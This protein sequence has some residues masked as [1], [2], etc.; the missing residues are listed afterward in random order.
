MTRNTTVSLQKTGRVAELILNRPEVLNAENWSMAHD[1]HGALD[2]LENAADISAVILSGAGRSF[3]SGVDLGA[4]SRGELKIDWFRSFDQAMRRIEQLDALTVAK[5]RGYAIGGG[6]QLTLACDLRVATPDARFGL[7]AVLEALIPGM[8]TYRLP[9]FI[10]LGRARRM[11]LTGEL[12]SSEEALRIG[13]VDWVVPE[14]QLTE[15]IDALI[16]RMSTGSATARGFTK[17]LITSSFE[18]DYDDAFSKYLE[19]Q[20]LSLRSDDHTRAMEEYRRRKGS[21]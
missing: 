9:R 14:E 8:G 17:K 4:L 7:P 20:E 6:L 13:L 18:S 10:G 3:S 2:E 12:I 5:I 11:A 16:A 1:L 15:T 19:F 21:L